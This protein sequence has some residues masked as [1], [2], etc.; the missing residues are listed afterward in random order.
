MDGARRQL[1]AGTGLAEDAHGHV[2][3]CHAGDEREDFAHERGVADDAF[4]RFAPGDGHAFVLFDDAAHAVMLGAGAEEGGQRV[5]RFGI[6]RVDAVDEEQLSVA[7]ENPIV[8]AGGGDRVEIRR[9]ER[10]SRSDFLPLAEGLRVAKRHVVGTK[11]RGVNGNSRNAASRRKRISMAEAVISRFGSSIFISVAI[12]SAVGVP[13]PSA[14]RKCFSFCEPVF[15]SPRFATPPLRRTRIA[16]WRFVSSI[17][18]DAPVERSGVS[19][20][21]IQSISSRMSAAASRICGEKGVDD[22]LG[23]AGG[24]GETASQKSRCAAI[25]SSSRGL[26]IAGAVVEVAK[27]MKTLRGVRPLAVVGREVGEDEEDAA[28][29]AIALRFLDERQRSQRF[30]ARGGPRSGGEEDVD[31]VECGMIRSVS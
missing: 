5:A 15:V 16:S 2:A 30:V 27:A 21:S 8:F 3:S 31:A 14:S 13:R 9:W 25:T 11:S 22:R 26:V 20:P 12:D 24:V 4:D 1:L 17:F 10:G 23:G 28:A 7:A 18:S 29:G 6:P 19:R